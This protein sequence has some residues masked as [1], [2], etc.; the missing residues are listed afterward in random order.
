M[1]SLVERFWAKVDKSADC[2]LWT[3]SLDS[4]GYGLI[5]DGNKKVKR[6]HR[7]SWELNVGNIPP[8]LQVCHKCDNR[9]CVNPQHLW[10]GSQKENM[11]D[12]AKKN[13]V[14]A[15]ISPETLARGPKHG[16]KTKP[17]CVLRGEKTNLAK[18]SEK[19]AKEIINFLAVGLTR[20]EISEKLQIS[21]D[22]VKHIHNNKTW[23][24]LNRP[25]FKHV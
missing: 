8:K 1:K 11:Q 20:R 10:L 16:S 21:Y 14:H 3:A 9:R 24:H 19:I 22:I 12:C 13:R 25:W 2:W 17:E 15:Q 18:I 5:G 7:V 23:T 6:A 4:C